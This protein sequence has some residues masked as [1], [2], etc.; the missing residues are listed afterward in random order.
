MINEDEVLYLP[1]YK[2]TNFDIHLFELKNYAYR[3]ELPRAIRVIITDN[4]MFEYG[5]IGS[6]IDE[7]LYN[8]H[9]EKYKHYLDKNEYKHGIY[10][11]KDIIHIDNARIEKFKEYDYGE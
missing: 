11:L 8:E 10:V 3:E 4:L 5:I 6:Q 9:K 1:N 7:K 2:L